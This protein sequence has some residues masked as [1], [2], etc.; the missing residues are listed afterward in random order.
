MILPSILLLVAHTLGA[1][2]GT[3]TPL[4]LARAADPSRASQD[5]SPRLLSSYRYVVSI[6][7]KG[8]SGHDPG[9]SQWATRRPPPRAQTPPP[10]HPS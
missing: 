1:N 8:D 7:D 3:W 6:E 4:P 2:V 10:T 5:T 9:I